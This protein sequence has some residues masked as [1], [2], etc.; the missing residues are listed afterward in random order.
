[1]PAIFVHWIT[2]YGEVALFGLL[3]VG[4]FGLPVP[5]ETL[6][7]LAGVMVRD[8]R[9]HFASTWAAAA[10][11]SMCGITLSYAM[12]R[13][14]GYGLVTRYGR[15]LHVTVDDLYRVEQWLARSGKWTLTF[16]Y[17]IP[18]VRHLTAVVAG[19]TELPM[20]IFAAFAYTGAIIWSLCFITLGWYVGDRW[21][22][23][24]ATAH[25]H[26]RIVAVAIL[27]C[28]AAYAF[29]H[30]RWLRRRS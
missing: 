14:I 29:I 25:R 28:A 23:A 24:L 26:L 1:M 5:D 8:G 4:V 27:V 16:G 15:L 19:T 17:F 22:E 30:T 20:P 13:I 7:T 2:A 12:G 9:L 21:E 6:L 11:G 3:V 18:G 10:F